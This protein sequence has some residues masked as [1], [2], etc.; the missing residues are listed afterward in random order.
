MSEALEALLQ[1]LHEKPK[2][3]N[4]STLRT[5]ATAVD[6]LGFLAERAAAPQGAN[7]PANILVVDD[8]A[9][10]R[11]AITH[12]LEKA[13][14]KC[15]SVEDARLA[16]QLF[17]GERYDLVF[18]DVD[19]PDMSGFELCAKLRALPGHEKTPVVFFVTDLNDFESRATSTMS[20][21]NDF[22]AKPFLFIEL[23]VKALVYVLRGKT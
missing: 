14:L 12:A 9:L 16:L 6:C 4:A 11:R 2:H 23:A 10:S 18:L 17:A 19:I 21:S 1:E 3:L 13:R 5:V 20:D 8:D 15:T 7:P 22:I